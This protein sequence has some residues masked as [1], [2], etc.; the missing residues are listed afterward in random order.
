M[1]KKRKD[2]GGM[3]KLGS[4]LNR[5]W[6]RHLNICFNASSMDNPPPPFQSARQKIALF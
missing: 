2:E 6:Q 4:R 3:I 5:Q 1:Q